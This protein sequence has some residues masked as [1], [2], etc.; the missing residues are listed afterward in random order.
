MSPFDKTSYT[1]DYIKTKQRQFMF[2]LSK[3]Y[4]T[5]MIEWLESKENINAYIKELIKKDM[6]QNHDRT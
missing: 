4:D 1:I 6:E 3:L 5:E 2:K